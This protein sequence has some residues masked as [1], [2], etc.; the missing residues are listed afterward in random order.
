MALDF[1]AIA[2]NGGFP[3]PTPT[4]VHRTVGLASWGYLDGDGLD[5]SEAVTLISEF[6]EDNLWVNAKL[7]AN[8]MFSLLK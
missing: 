5:I 4:E 1:F 3:E 2:S 6:L 7:F 8:K